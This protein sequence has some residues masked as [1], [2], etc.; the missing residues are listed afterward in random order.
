MVTRQLRS[1]ASWTSRAF[2]SLE[3]CIFT[4]QCGFSTFYAVDYY[5]FGDNSGG[6]DHC[7]RKIQRGIEMDRRLVSGL[8]KQFHPQE[9]VP[10]TQ[11]LNNVTR[12]YDLGIPTP[13]ESWKFDRQLSLTA[14]LRWKKTLMP[15]LWLRSVCPLIAVTALRYQD[16]G[17]IRLTRHSRR[18][19]E[20][21]S[22]SF[23]HPFQCPLENTSE[24]N[25]FIV[26]QISLTRIHFEPPVRSRT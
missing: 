13:S 16:R 12:H 11:V 1:T 19:N 22:Y 17:A 24:W 8:P 4:L 26:P 20:V 7:H 21:L 2:Q 23:L 25:D 15:S 5:G 6:E 10:S 3:F 18:C 14:L 9:Y